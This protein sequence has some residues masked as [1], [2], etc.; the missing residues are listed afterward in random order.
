[1]PRITPEESERM[2]ARL[3]ATLEAQGDEKCYFPCNQC[4][5][6]NRRIFVRKTIEKHCCRNEHYE[7]GYTYCS[8]V[9]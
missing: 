1:M 7:G 4:R 8:M 3:R 5:G 9:S 2:L 6:F